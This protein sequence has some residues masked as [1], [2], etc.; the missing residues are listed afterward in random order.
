MRFVFRSQKRRQAF[1]KEAL[2]HLDAMYGLALRL[3]R[4]PRETEDLVQDAVVKAF[5]F[6][7]RFEE[8]SNIKAWLF[9][10]LVNTFYNRVRKEKNTARLELEAELDSNYQRFLSASTLSGQKSEELFLE[11]L[12]TEELRREVDELPEEFRTAVL[13]S[14]LYDFSY[15]EIAD[16]VGCPVG[17]VMSRLYRGRRL[18]Q[19]RLYDYALEQGYLRPPAEAASLDEYRQRRG[20]QR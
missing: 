6:F 16:I 17:T 18:L 7:H 13:L 9:K 3:T 5:R 4:D 14:D 11:G 15:K 20:T 10:V 8:G 2:P 1:E 19:K 12:V